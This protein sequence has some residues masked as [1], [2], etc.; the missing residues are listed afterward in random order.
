MRTDQLDFPP[1]L[2]VVGWHEGETESSLRP[3]EKMRAMASDL[4][5]EIR[6]ADWLARF[7]RQAPS[8]SDGVEF[9][10]WC[11]ADPRHLAAYLRLM[12]VWNRLDALE[13]LRGA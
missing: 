10:G 4:D 1:A 11:R 8:A 13:L 3:E 6:A 9:E 7:D 2:E 5:I 12:D